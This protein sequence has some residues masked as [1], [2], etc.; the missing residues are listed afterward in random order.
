MSPAR[1]TEERKPADWRARV[2]RRIWFVEGTEV[3][4][5]RAFEAFWRWEQTFER[6]TR[7]MIAS[8][9]MRLGGEGVER[10]VV[11]GPE[12]A[13]VVDGTSSGSELNSQLV[14]LTNLGAGDGN[15]GG[16]LSLSC[17]QNRI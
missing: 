4:P 16:S 3:R 8:C 11:Q 2:S 13:Q 15:S 1:V 9:I 7:D 6:C 17:A 5:R 14:Q 10:V 12:W